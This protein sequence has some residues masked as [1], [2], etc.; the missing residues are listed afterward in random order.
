M[1]LTENHQQA[2]FLLLA[3]AHFVYRFLINNLLTVTEAIFNQL[4]VQILSFLRGR[5]DFKISNIC[6]N[7]IIIQ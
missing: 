4:V 7:T 6:W 5:K 1:M 3:N 2:V